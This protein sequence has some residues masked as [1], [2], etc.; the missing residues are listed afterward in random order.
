MV[1]EHIGEHGAI[2]IVVFFHWRDFITFFYLVQKIYIGVYSF[3]FASGSN[4]A[5][6]RADKTG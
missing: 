4:V 2:D 3:L 1:N 5:L 6:G